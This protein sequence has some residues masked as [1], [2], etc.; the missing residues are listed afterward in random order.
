MKKSAKPV[1]KSGSK[2]IPAGKVKSK[3]PAKQEHAINRNVILTGFTS[4]FT[5]ISSEM[6]YPLLQAFVSFMLAAQKAILGPILGLIEGIAESTASLLKVYSGYISDK[7]EKRK[8]PT[9]I[10]YG[11]SAFAK[12][13]LLL[14][15]FGW[16]L[17]LLSRFFDRV[18]KG[19][20][21]AP[22]DALISESTPKEFQGRAFGFH[23]GM[24]FAGAT[25]GALFAYF[26]VLQFIDPVTKNLADFRSFYTIFL[27]SFI[28]AALGVVFL[29]FVK[30]KKVEATAQ[31]AKPKPN[32]NFRQY[33]KNLQVF[34]LAQ[35][36]FTLGNSSNQFLLLRS[37]EVGHAL[38]TVI[39]MYII[40]NLSSTLL[41]TFFGD[42]SDKIGRKK[43]LLAGYILYGL[44]Y[45]A[46]GFVAAENHNLL[47]VFWPIYGIY[48]AM[49]EGVEKAFI[50]DV[51][52][53]DSK[54]TALG[55]YHTIVG[56]GLL[57]ASLIAGLLFAL[58][59]SA[60]FIFGS[61]MA[62][63]AVIIISIFVKE[64]KEVK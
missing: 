59:P 24:D 33:N 40:F 38:S 39:L 41:S 20:R 29:F 14:S 60:P 21:S 10:G 52:P 57:P 51:A 56:I 63:S 61:L 44:V 7:I 49:T 25:L 2:T 55:F 11:T 47:W 45:L 1:S 17:V 53:K 62:I 15:G 30:E 23:R 50:A 54:A 9:I 26:L 48:Y 13:L 43:V 19:V 32:L 36:I 6:I 35:F 3:G 37:M 18:G 16:Y 28:P 46:F 34:F 22:R 4:F 31:K 12:L 5:D 42:L 64:A 8:A 58:A 27:L